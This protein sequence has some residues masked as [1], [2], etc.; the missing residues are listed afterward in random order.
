MTADEMSREFDIYYNNINSNSCPGLDEYEKTV[1]LNK[2]QDVIVKDAFNIG[3]NPERSNLDIE[4]NRINDFSN[5]II[6]KQSILTKNTGASLQADNIYQVTFDSNVLFVL[7][8]FISS[9][10]INYPVVPK[11]FE[12]FTKLMGNPYPYPPKNI[13][14]RIIGAQNND[15]IVLSFVPKNAAKHYIRYVKLPR[16]IVLNKGTFNGSGTSVN[17]ELSEV[18]HPEIVHKAAQL[19]KMAYAGNIGQQA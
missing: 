12:D 5:L 19:A 18:L 1:F 3:T 7:N 2:A 11:N 8:E 6:E 14:W 4:K 15:I 13:A 10:N 16:R 9:N 17:C